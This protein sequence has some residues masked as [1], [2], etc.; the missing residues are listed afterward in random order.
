MNYINCKISEKLLSIN[1]F[2]VNIKVRIE[3]INN[4]KNK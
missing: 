2:F 3:M 1:L 4:G